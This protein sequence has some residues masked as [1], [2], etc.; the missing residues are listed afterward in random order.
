[1]LLRRSLFLD[2]GQ[3]LLG[4]CNRRIEIGF[5][6]MKGVI[7]GLLR[8]RSGSEGINTILRST[9]QICAYSLSAGNKDFNGF[10]HGEL[11][12]CG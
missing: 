4:I 7:H 1:M 11:V 5:L 6:M 9:R 2:E 8:F 3:T 12:L 10:Q